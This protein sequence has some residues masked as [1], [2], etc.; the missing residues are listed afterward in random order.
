[1]RGV[2]VTILAAALWCSH[3]LAAPAP[4]DP[5]IERIYLELG[6]GDFAHAGDDSAAL[7]AHLRVQDPMRMA[8]LDLRLDVLT[9]RTDTSKPDGAAL[10]E[11]ID[12]FAAH[13]PRG[14]GLAA[15][16]KIQQAVERGDG[17][18]AADLAQTLPDVVR[19]PAEVDLYTA[20][21][22][23]LV[24]GRLDEVRERA[25]RALALWHDRRGMRA[26][27]IE[28]ELHYT[29]GTAEL[30]SG[31][32]ASALAELERGAKLAIDAFGPESYMRFRMDAE[33]AGVFSE[34]GR[35]REALELREGLYETAKRSYGENSVQAAKAE[36]LLGAALQEIGDYGTARPHYEHAQKILEAAPDTFAHERII[37]AANFANLLQEMDEEQAALTQYQKALDL[38]GTSDDTM[39]MRAV[40]NANIGNTEVK[41]QRYEDAIVYYRRALE[42]REKSDGKESPGLAYSLEGLGSASLLLKRYADAEGYF[43]RALDLRQKGTQPN[44]PSIGPLRFGLALARWGEGDTADAFRIA[45]E[46]AEHQQEILSTFAA[47]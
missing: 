4:A 5:R 44:H 45:V 19:D 22:L 23:A 32:S 41:L 9:V 14:R 10:A 47:D 40:I 36:G 27:M 37:L 39:H 33:R 24:P 11:A 34:L 28:V 8:A 6:K 20:R 13:D 30:Y 7:L 43:R 35:S 46:A 25:N 42:L 12:T 2:P 18:A 3:A 29:I 17:K 16:L 26:R 38:T 31:S 15:R 1:M 21:A